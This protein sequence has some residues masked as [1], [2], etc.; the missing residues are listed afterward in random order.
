MRRE[1]WVT[2]QGPVKEQQPDG[3]SHRGGAPTHPP[4][5]APE[6]LQLPLKRPPRAV[7]TSAAHAAATDLLVAP[8]GCAAE[9][10][11]VALEAVVGESGMELGAGARV[12]LHSASPGGW[13]VGWGLHPPPPAL[14]PDFIVGNNES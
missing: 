14:D 7:G 1:E 4:P 2:V 9:I 3:M 11:V 5:P 6:K 10:C 12:L 13:G 8:S